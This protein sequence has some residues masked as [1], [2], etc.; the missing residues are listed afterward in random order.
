[1][2]SRVDI[3]EEERKDFFLY[4]DEFQN[5]ATE[6]FANILSEARKYR[7]SLILSHQYITQLDETVCDAVFGNV[8]TL[9]SFRV[10]ADD[11]EWLEKEFTPEFLA[12][13]FVNLS[14][15]HI[16]VKL[17]IDGL[18]GR[19]FSGETLPPIPLPE[20]S[21]REEIV[22]ASRNTYSTPLAEVERQISEWAGMEELQKKTEQLPIVPPDP[23]PLLYD[24]VCSTCNKPTKLVFAPDGTRPVYC[25]VCRKKHKTEQE[26][27]LALRGQ[28]PSVPRQSQGTAPQPKDGLRQALHEALIL[29]KKEEEKRGVLK[30]GETVHF[31]E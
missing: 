14:K 8:G 24:A 2:M 27:R 18:A 29:N 6:S 12:G 11:A 13:D 25:K 16:Y 30:P 5:F 15:Y 9:V 28:G 7:L 17:M 22:Q 3:L 19:P 26:R 21:R 1:A 31:A 20:G 4:I 10:G 23:A